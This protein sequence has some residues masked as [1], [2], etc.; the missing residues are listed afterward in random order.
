MARVRR[1][2]Q[3][4]SGVDFLVTVVEVGVSP[5]ICG[6]FGR[7][8]LAAQVRK[9]ANHLPHLWAGIRPRT[10]RIRRGDYDE[11]RFEGG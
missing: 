6:Q 11:A 2:P 1:I 10:D 5:W 7:C 9:A 4:M 8:L 3:D